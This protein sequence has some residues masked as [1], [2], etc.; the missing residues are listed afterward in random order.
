MEIRNSQA[1]EWT[2]EAG[3][4]KLEDQGPNT[5]HSLPYSYQGY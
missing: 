5:S 3:M 2:I 1:K 4:E